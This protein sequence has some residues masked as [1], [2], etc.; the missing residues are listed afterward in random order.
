MLSENEIGRVLVVTAHPDDVDFAAAGTIAQFTD[1]GVEVVYCIVTDGDAGGFDRELDNTGMAELRR[2]EQTAAAKAVGVTDLR[3]LGHR[4]G[5]LVPGLEL[6][7]DIA[8]VIRQVRP[9]LVITH[10]PERN[11]SFIAPSHPDHRAVGASALDA[12]Y[13][14]ARNPYAF[15][16]LLRDE[17]L[18]AWTV[19]E[20]W[21]NGGSSPD[22]FVDVTGTF[23][24]KIAAL[25]AHASQTSHVEGFEEFLRSRFSQIA[26]EAGLP[27]GSYAEGFQRVVTE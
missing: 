1:R 21:L 20:V 3:F 2:T 23:D 17:G 8:R 24:R 10:T 26:A 13:P 4:D 9:D 6:R 12:V 14:D 11:Y 5:T 27:E 15:P 25:R 22:H 16:E 7:R 18:D 19:R